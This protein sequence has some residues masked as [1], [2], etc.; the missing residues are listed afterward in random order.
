MLYFVV[1]E[2]GQVVGAYHPSIS[3]PLFIVNRIGSW[4]LPY[5]YNSTSIYILYVLF[6]VELD[7]IFCDRNRTGSWG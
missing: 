1:I 5:F 4:G 7:F 2:I 6:T 3:L